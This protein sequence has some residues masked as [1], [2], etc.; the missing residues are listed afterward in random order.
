MLGQALGAGVVWLRRN[1]RVSHCAAMVIP[2]TQRRSY[3]SNVTSNGALVVVIPGALAT[4][5]YP[6]PT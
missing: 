2:V 1:T 3:G 5:V 6:L 4:S